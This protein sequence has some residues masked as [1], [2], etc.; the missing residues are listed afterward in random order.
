MDFKECLNNIW[1]KVLKEWECKWEVRISI[2]IIIEVDTNKEEE[3]AVEEEVD[4]TIKI[5]E[6][7]LDNNKCLINN[8]N[9]THLSNSLIWWTSQDN[10]KCKDLWIKYITNNNNNLTFKVTSKDL[11][12][13]FN[14]LFKFRFLKLTSNNILKLKIKRPL[15]E[16]LFI[17]KYLQY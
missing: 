8:S 5:E 16:M 10:N 12:Y 2:W 3:E 14:R 7:K 17:H 9:N 13:R 15:L 4:K 6:V 1:D 11:K